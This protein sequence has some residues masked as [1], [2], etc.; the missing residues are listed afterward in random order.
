MTA[1]VVG[2]GPAG[3]L[4]ATLLARD[5]IDV[6]VVSDGEGSL[7]LWSGDFSF[8]SSEEQWATYPSM[9]PASTWWGW[10]EELV[11][12]LVGAGVPVAPLPDRTARSAPFPLTL[13]P[14]GHLRPTLV[15]PTWQHA[16]TSPGAV[17]LVDLDGLPD[18]IGTA[19]AAA[20]H[21]ATNQ[22]ATLVTLPRPPRWTPSWGAL[23]YAAWFDLPEGRDWL[24]HQLTEAVAPLPVDAPVLLPGVIGIA[25]VE[26]ALARASEAIGR[27]VFER[28]IV[29]PNV[30]GI[31]VRER[32]ECHLRAKGVIFETGHVTRLVQGALALADGRQW[33]DDL[34]IV[35]AGGVL[36]GGLVVDPSGTVV[37][38]LLGQE[39]ARCS[40]P[41]DLDT[42]GRASCAV[43]TRAFAA[44]REIAGWNP[45]RDHNGGA[46]VVATVA[47]ALA[48]AR[49]EAK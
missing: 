13:T 42:V 32:W 15:R 28:P 35:A 5:G 20:Y 45:N 30:A 17:V 46:M 49:E 41:T 47:E 40:T 36:G 21:A 3:L 24:A 33:H 34:V 43:G 6:R 12:V 7:A 10:V 26:E 4:A 19:Q 25:H 29:T 31:R 48:R 38:P 9:R 8:G 14:L 27:P 18:A 39:V 22:A 16:T 44:G 37:D 1:T 23:R 2:R 11:D